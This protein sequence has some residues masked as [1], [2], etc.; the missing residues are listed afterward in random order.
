MVI[1]HNTVQAPDKPFQTIMGMPV[2]LAAEKPKISKP[3]RAGRVSM[4]HG[5]GGAVRGGRPVLQRRA[6]VDVL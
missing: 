2:P 3:G 6:T 1:V 4:Y 5:A